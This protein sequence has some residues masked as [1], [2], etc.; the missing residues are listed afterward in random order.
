MLE[1]DRIT[2]TSSATLVVDMPL[3]YDHTTL[4]RPLENKIPLK[5]FLRSFLAL[6]KN[7]IAFNA[8][9]KMINHC[10]Q[11]RE[12]PTTQRVVNQVLHKN[13][14]SGE[15]RLSVYIGD[16]DMDRV[17]LDLG[18]DVNVLSKKIWEMMGK[19]KLIW[20]PV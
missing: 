9:H 12:L 3:I 17:I 2:S 5:E 4:E 14:T 11:E 13:R 6:M 16:Y 7:E 20:S 8:L 18:F 10:V 1:P 15:F 19:L